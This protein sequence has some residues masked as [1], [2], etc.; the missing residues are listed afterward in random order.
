MGRLGG[1]CWNVCVDLADTAE[2]AI[3]M[4]AANPHYTR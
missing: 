4:V 3:A 1:V 2:L